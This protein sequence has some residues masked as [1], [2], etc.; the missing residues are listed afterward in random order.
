MALCPSCGKDLPG[1]FPFCPFCTAPLVEKP[2]TTQ[3]E[4]RKV[5]S[6]LFCDLVGFTAASE[7]ADPEDVRA[8]LR[9]YHARLKAEIERFGGTV[10]KF[11]GDAVMAV[12]GAPVAHEDDAERAVRAGLTILDAIAELN[13]DD[14]ELDLQVRVGINTG[15]AVVALGVRPEHGEGMVTGDV[16]NTAARIQTAAPVNAV[17]VSE[18][19]YRATSRVFD[20]EPL[21]AVSV[22]GKAEPVALWRPKAAHARFGSD[23]ARQF[24]TPLVGRELEKP[25]LIGIFERAAQQRAVQLV[26]VVGEPGVGKTRL[27]GELFAYIEVKPG[28][29]RWRQGR[30]LPYGEGITFWALGEIIKAEAGILEADSAEV[31]AA[32]LSAA[33]SPDESEKQWLVQRLSPLVGVE[34]ASPAE[35]QELFTAWRRFFEGLAASRSTVLVFEDL[36]WADEA[37]LA[38]LEHLAEWSEGV[39]LLIVCAARPELYER[40]PGWGAG[41]RNAHVINLSPLSDGETAELVSHLI[42]T[43]VL[44]TELQ[45][46]ILERAG[47]NPL[48]AEEFVRLLAD[49]GGLDAAETALP[50]TVQALIAARLDTLTPER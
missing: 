21:E 45:Q 42:S 37:L 25:L 18:Q 39:P 9:P 46:A 10:E 5:V 20:Y 15:E 28:I 6:V 41:L 22:K 36:H 29:I 43:T 50:D 23:I 40:R 12:F 33:V 35:R 38:F 1:E 48:Y 24:K 8:T 26:T 34:A 2:S 49:R 27:I 44:T 31:A 19:T 11:V 16:V 17:A 47:G 14:P 32:K 4:E 13:E 30:C 3:L 7:Q